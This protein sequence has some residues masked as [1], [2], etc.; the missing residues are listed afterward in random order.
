MHV[1]FDR[2]QQYLALSACAFFFL[3]LHVRNQLRNGFLRDTRALDDLWKKHLAGAEKIADNA[4][5]AHERS[6]N[7][8]Q[9]LLVLL[10]CFLDILVDVIDDSF[11][12]RVFQT[13]FHRSFAPFIFFHL[14]LACLLYRIREHQQAFGGVVPAIE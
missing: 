12:Q 4:H 1:S 2:S 11:D 6:F 3:R 8:L 9:R 10:A 5:G 7:D 14:G 13:F